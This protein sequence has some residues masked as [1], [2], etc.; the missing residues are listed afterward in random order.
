MPPRA[1]ASSVPVAM[2]S[3]PASPVRA[4]LR[5]RNSSTMDG[6]NF[7]AAPKPAEASS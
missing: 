3:V 1:I 5:S 4:W 6:G 2:R 7:G